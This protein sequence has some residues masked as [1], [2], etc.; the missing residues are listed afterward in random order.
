MTKKPLGRGLSALISTDSPLA[1][2]DEIRDIEIDLVRPGHQQPRTSFDQAK[3]EELAQSIRTSG[4]IQPLLVR[5]RGGLFELVA[6]ERRWRAAQLAGLPRVPVIIREIPDD[7]LLELALIENIQRQELNPI[8]EA[9]AYKRLIESL[10]LTQEEVAQRVGRDRT[11]VTNYL[12]ILKLPLEIQTLLEEEKLSF[13]HARALLGIGDIILQRRYAQK[14]VKHN[15]SVRETERRIKHA[16]PDISSVANPAPKQTDPNIRAA[17]AKLRRH[18]GTQV[19]IVPAKAGSAGKIQIEYYSPLDL[20]RL[21]TIII[22]SNESENPNTV[23]ASR[24]L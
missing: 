13:G 16:A 14:I 12:R 8:E 4:I 23:A 21:Y 2:S 3:L 19:Q 24:S 1:D 18:L 9:N 20:D 15:W 10:N 17:E 7:K 22:S 6:G 5:P 11:F